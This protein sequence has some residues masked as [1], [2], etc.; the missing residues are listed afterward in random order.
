M[1]DHVERREDDE[2]LRGT[3]APFFRA[4]ES[5]IAMACF[6]LV[7]FLPDLPL[8]NVPFL[9]SRMAFFTSVPAFLLYL[10]IS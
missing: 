6:R 9:R 1:K 4:F 3:L 10:G 8:F 7:T 5:P 2:F